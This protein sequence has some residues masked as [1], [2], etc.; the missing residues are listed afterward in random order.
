MHTILDWGQVTPEGT[1]GNEF[2]YVHNHDLSSED[3]IERTIRFVVGRLQYYKMHLPPNASHIIKFD[4]RGQRLPHNV[5][6]LISAGIK[7]KLGESMH[8]IIDFIK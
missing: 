6:E 5:E 1:K 4:I 3:K 8:F 2:L 7:A